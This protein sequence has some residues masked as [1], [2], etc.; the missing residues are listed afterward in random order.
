MSYRLHDVHRGD[1]VVFDRVTTTGTQVSHDDLIKRVVG[2]AGE[3]IE[4]RDCNVYINGTVLP[5]AYL[6]KRDTQKTDLNAR[7]RV[8]SMRR[9]T[10]PKGHVF[11]MGDNRPESFDSRSFGSVPT[12]LIVGRAFAVVWPV[13]HAQSL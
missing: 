10:I 4:I 5:E 1:V 12:S 6:P 3:T 8:V 11:V 9:I 13:S 7:C 2:L